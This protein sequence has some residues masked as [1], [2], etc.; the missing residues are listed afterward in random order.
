MLARDSTWRLLTTWPTAAIREH[1]GIECQCANGSRFISHSEIEQHGTGGKAVAWRPL[2]PWTIRDAALEREH[3]EE[4]AKRV[5]A[6][7]LERVRRG[8]KRDR[9]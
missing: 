8:V 5:T 3:D 6:A 7:E 9:G 2:G 1:G 4:L